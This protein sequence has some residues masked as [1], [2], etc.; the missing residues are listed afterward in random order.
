[1][2]PGADEAIEVS[3]V[4]GDALLSRGYTGAYLGL[5][6]AHEDGAGGDHADFDWLLF[7]PGSQ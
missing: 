6:A 3:R 4:P 7:R 2:L 1:V 5:Y